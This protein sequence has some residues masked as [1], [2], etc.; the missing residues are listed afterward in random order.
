[1]RSALACIVVLAAFAAGS[2]P[3]ADP[4]AIE[5]GL[6]LA[7][8]DVRIA[9]ICLADAMAILKIPS[10]SIAVVERGRLDWAR[11]YGDATPRTLYQAASMS[12]LVATGA[13]A[14]ST[15]SSVT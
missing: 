8:P 14:R 3:A 11:A 7:G 2:A 12:K 10:V 13:T 9:N 6:D 5:R 4:G 15:R 1:M